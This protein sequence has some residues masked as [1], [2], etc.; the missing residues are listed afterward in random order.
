VTSKLSPEF[1][2]D[3]SGGQLALDLANTISRRDDPARRREHLESYADAL[4]FLRQSRALTPQQAN[5]LRDHALQ[6]PQEARRSFANIVKLREA[7][8]RLF[9]DVAQGKPVAGTDLKLVSQFAIEAL[10]HRA[11]TPHNGGYGWEWLTEQRNGLDRALWPMA[12]AAADLLI[13][14]ELKI[15]RFCEA[16]DCQWLFL[17]HSRNRS[18]RWCDMASCGNRAKARRHYQ[19]MRE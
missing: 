15:V 19:R 4:S 8:Y 5:H 16:P 2:F 1:Q 9:A 18:R 11:L 7:V 6:H 14:D 10:R 3:L 17:D 13:S 12:Q